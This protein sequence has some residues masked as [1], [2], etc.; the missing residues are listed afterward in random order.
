MRLSHSSLIIIPISACS[1]NMRW[2]HTSLF[3]KIASH[4]LLKIS[5]YTSIPTDFC[6]VL[7]KFMLKIRKFILCEHA[8]NITHLISHSPR[9]SFFA[10]SFSVILLYLASGSIY[11]K[12]FHANTLYP[13][14]SASC[15]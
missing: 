7:V 10:H 11:S 9:I 2:R 12:L 3:Y 15:V 13:S 14:I 8:L 1:Y 6:F 4:N 5:M